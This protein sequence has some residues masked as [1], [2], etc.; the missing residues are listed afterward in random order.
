MEMETAVEISTAPLHVLDAICA[1]YLDH[2]LATPTRHGQEI[3]AHRMNGHIK[4]SRG[5]IPAMAWYSP[6]RKWEDAGNIITDFLQQNSI[7][8]SPWVLSELIRHII[9]V[10]YGD[11]VHIPHKLI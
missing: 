6:T 2:D 3:W 10:E 9:M 8:R 4:N 5:V 7:P 11:I 1:L